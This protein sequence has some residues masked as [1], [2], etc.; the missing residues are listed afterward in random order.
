M[1]RARIKIFGDLKTL[2][3]TEK[4][5]GARFPAFPLLVV[6]CGVV[7]FAVQT[8]VHKLCAHN[9]TT[10]KATKRATTKPPKDPQKVRNKVR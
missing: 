4:C 1:G 10:K 7:F 3:R 9:F 6:L 5:H 2:D 8:G